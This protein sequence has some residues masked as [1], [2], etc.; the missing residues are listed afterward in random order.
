M[1]RI[2]IKGKKFENDEGFDLFTHHDYDFPEFLR[3]SEKTTGLSVIDV[4]FFDLKEVKIGY[5]EGVKKLGKKGIKR[6]KGYIKYYQKK[7]EHIIK[8]GKS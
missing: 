2:E 6:Y 5:L 3:I 7:Y 1:K 4:L 8:E